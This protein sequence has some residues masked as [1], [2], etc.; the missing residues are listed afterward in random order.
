[1]ARVTI[2]SQA[3]PATQGPLE[4]QLQDAVVLAIVLGALVAVMDPGILL[5]AAVTGAWIWLH[6]PSTR[7]R[8]ACAV[9]IALPVLA[10]QS[11]V[12]WGW[13]WRDWLASTAFLHVSPVDGSLVLRSIYTEA[14][15]G[16]LW[17]EGALFVTHLRRRTV[18]AQVRRDHRLD[19]RRWRAIRE[20]AQP[21]FPVR[22]AKALR[23]DTSPEHPLDRIRIGRDLET[24]TALDLEL[25]SDLAAHVFLPG[26][27]GSGKT[28]TIARLADGA[29]ACGYG[30]AMIDCKAG[31]LENTARK[32]ASRY[33]LPF[34]L[35]NPDDPSS[36]GYNPCNGDA[37]SVANKVVG[38]FTFAPGA[39]IYKNIAME[40]VA[41]A[42][43]GLQATNQPVT[44]DSLYDAFSPRGLAMIAQKV[45]TDD[46]L[47]ARL[48]ALEPRS[49][50]RLG[51]AGRTGLQRR[52]GALLEGKFGNLFRTEPALD[53]D[54]V[55][56]EQSV[57]YIA[58][59]ALANSEDVDLMGRVIVQDLKQLCARRLQQLAEGFKP[60]P[61]IVVLDEFAALDEPEQLLDLLRQARE[62]LVSIVISTQHMPETFALQAACL[63][64]G[65]LIVH[66]VATEDAQ[67]IAAQFGT[68]PANDL[69]HQMDYA[70]G[71]SEKGSVR[72]IDR[73][74]V[75]PN[76]FREL[77]P[78]QVALKS[79]SMRQYAIVRI[80]RDRAHGS[81]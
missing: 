22:S 38:T 23:A 7:Q 48:L 63:G 27:S 65:L 72:R 14:L 12:V 1:M 31:G 71:F 80:Y 42:V 20:Q 68:R 70:N 18:H 76:E 45:T 34:Y 17:L 58:L 56:S 57:A 40:S 28:N 15:A 10:L 52:L 61:L 69:T 32:L 75:H 79:V 5:G 50:D 8:L 78:G 9:L 43:R 19:K 60:Q 16:P 46:R 73:Y 44:L 6:Q 81:H 13:P 47:R 51:I 35:V 3:A 62:A 74:N 11:F 54:N 37:P 49:G 36:L 55:G 4:T 41:V 26:A 59:S 33:A 29:L 24:N 64:A 25:P 66:R 67:I 21:T 53:W 30:L 2:E 39:E 77:T